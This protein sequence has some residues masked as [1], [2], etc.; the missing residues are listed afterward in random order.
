MNNYPE[1]LLRGGFFLSSV[2]VFGGLKRNTPSLWYLRVQYPF[3]RTI[4]DVDDHAKPSPFGREVIEWPYAA[5]GAAPPP[6]PPGP[7]LQ[8][9]SDHRGT[10]RNVQKGKSGPA[11]FGTQ[12]L[13]SQTP[14][15][16]RLI[17]PCHLGRRRPHCRPP[18]RPSLAPHQLPRV[19]QP[20]APPPLPRAS[21]SGTSRTCASRWWWT[22][23]S[24]A[25]PPRPW[26]P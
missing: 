1:W 10:Q 20:T 8:D 6:P 13:G 23:A 18:P 16:P 4:D 9:H 25:S 14:P 12:T 22:R 26:G 3:P 17:P 2:L 5:G 11:I 19:P 24:W 7:P 15:P 21:A